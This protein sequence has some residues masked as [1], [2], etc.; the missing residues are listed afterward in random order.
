MSNPITQAGRR[1]S[2]GLQPEKDILDPD[3]P[4]WGARAIY[5]SG[6]SPVIDIPWDRQAMTGSKER[7]EALSQWINEHGLKLL[8][9]ELY[10]QEVDGRSRKLVTICHN[11]FFLQANPQASC[12]Y[13]YLVAFEK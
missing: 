3:E 6:V 12:G 5:K 9:E 1:T 11:G 8:K 7:R 4:L 10:Q 2:W 13:L